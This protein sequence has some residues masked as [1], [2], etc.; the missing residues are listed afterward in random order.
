MGRKG[1]RIPQRR[2]APKS[3]LLRLLLRTPCAGVYSRHA[4]LI[5]Q[6]LTAIVTEN[7]CYLQITIKETEICLR[8]GSVRCADARGSLRR[9]SRDEAFTPSAL[10]FDNRL[11]ATGLHKA[12]QALRGV[13]HSLGLISHGNPWCQH[14]FLPASQHSQPSGRDFQA[15]IQG[16]DCEGLQF[17]IPHKVVPNTTSHFRM[18]KLR[19][20]KVR[21]TGAPRARPA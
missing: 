20:E 7:R 21:N 12:K 16:L 13:M 10:D 19:P 6:Y 11:L 8:S 17:P 14:W 5:N 2:R 3:L 9:G 4:K 18:E 1:W 15:L